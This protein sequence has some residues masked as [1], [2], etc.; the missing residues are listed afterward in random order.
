MRFV[1]KIFW[2]RKKHAHFIYWNGFLKS[3]LINIENK[4]GIDS[5]FVFNNTTL[6]NIGHCNFSLCNIFICFLLK[7]S[8]ISKLYLFYLS[9]VAYII[10]VPPKSEQFVFAFIFIKIDGNICLFKAFFSINLNA[11]KIFSYHKPS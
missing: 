11:F 7:N 2:S 3:K 9:V 4:R 1:N 10:C 5:V 8:I 6:P